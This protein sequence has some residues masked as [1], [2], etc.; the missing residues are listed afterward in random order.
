MI[1][2]PP[3]STLFPYTT[4]FRSF[5]SKNT[6]L[7]NEVVE[8]KRTLKLSEDGLSAMKD[9]NSKLT[10]ELLAEKAKNNFFENQI[11]KIAGTV[12]SL[13]K[14]SKTDP[15]LLKKYSKVFFLSEN[16]APAKLT[17]IN[18][19]YL[20]EKDRRQ[21]IYEKVLPYLSDLL[22]DAKANDV[23][24]KIVSAYRS[25]GTQSSLKSNY[26]VIYGSGTANRF[27]ADQGYSEHQLGTTVDL[28]TPELGSNYT[29]FGTT[30]AYDW[31]NK[32][33][34]RYGFILSYPKG[35]SYY[36]FEPWHWRFVGVALARTLHNE[37]QN[38]YDLDQRTI[39]NYLITIFN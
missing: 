23:P 14:L 26:K 4:L 36:Q 9:N 24:I 27:S 13:E 30:D 37:N 28:T 17:N 7:N 18:P 33:A 12:G 38:F 20:Y 16:Y 34:Y 31:L 2:R 6:S 21:Q 19:E 25:F 32:N 1:R 11:S 10:D 39:D 5:Y 8:L 3:R 22:I 29:K 15:E 35:N